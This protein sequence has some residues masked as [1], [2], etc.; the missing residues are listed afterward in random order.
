MLGVTYDSKD[1]VLDIAL[2]RTDHLVYRP[3]ASA[4]LESDGGLASIAVTAA[5]GSTQ[6]VRLKEP[7]AL[8]TPEG[9]PSAR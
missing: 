7:L 8:P 9:Q 6:I 1:D 2:D 4:V 5:D 3:T